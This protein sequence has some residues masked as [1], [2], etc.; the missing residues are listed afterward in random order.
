MLG[1]MDLVLLGC[2]ALALILSTIA[3]YRLYFHPCAKFPGPALW[4]ISR[5]PFAY[6]LYRGNNHIKIHELHNKYG[7]VVRVAPSEI[8]FI[9]AEAWN[10]IYGKATNKSSLAKDNLQFL[11][12]KG[13]EHDLLFEPDDNEHARMRYVTR[14]TLVNA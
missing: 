13:Q 5:I 11:R 1:I 10:D 4:A 6:Y 7:P 2:T 8:S 3:L 9:D 12:A 14:L